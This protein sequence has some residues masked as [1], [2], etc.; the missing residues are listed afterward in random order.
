MNE[1]NF[2]TPGKLTLEPEN[3]ELEDDFP[4]PGGGFSGSMLILSATVG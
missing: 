3:G 2:Y 4:F 1:V